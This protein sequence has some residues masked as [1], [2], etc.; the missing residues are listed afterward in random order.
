[1][2]QL[3]YLQRLVLSYCIVL[4]LAD[5]PNL[6]LYEV[7]FVGRYIIGTREFIFPAEPLYEIS[8]L[9]PT[10][11]YERIDRVRAGGGLKSFSDANEKYGKLFLIAASLVIWVVILLLFKVY[12][13]DETW[14][15]WHV[16]VEHPQF[17]DFRLIPG[18]AESFRMGF[19]P[20]QRNPGDPHK[21]IFNYPAFWRL[22]FY[23]GITQEHSLWAVAVML[24]LFFLGVFLFPQNITILESIALLLVIFSP[25]SMLLYERGNVDLIVFFL[26]ALIVWS[27]EI[28]AFVAVALLSFAIVVKI[29]PF[30]G[31]TVLLTESKTRFIWLFL[32]CLAVLLAY[33]YS[34]SGSV[35]AAWN[36]TMRGDEIS[37]GANVLFLRYSQY[38]SQLLRVSQTDPKLKFE[39]VILA[40]ILI[41]IAGLIGIT[42]REPL[43]SASTRNLAAFRMGASI[44]IGTFLLGNN[45][46]YRLAF[47][48]FVVPQLMEWTRKSYPRRYRTIAVSVLILVFTSCWHFVVWFAPGLASVKEFLFVLDETMNWMLVAGFSYLLC[49]SIPDWLRIEFNSSL[50]K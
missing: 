17:S 1:M 46:D 18:S 4:I 22:F 40:A 37:Y 26:C 30:F 9:N 35:R 47:L 44:Y 25:A 39:P 7:V 5:S 16:P 21:R 29:F 42:S 50:Q 12:G 43:K 38:F 33:M 20:T 45:W 3:Y 34:T 2:G 36:L 32:T 48:I 19:E 24:G 11:V 8:A 13:Y 10:S 49:A 28:S 23:T 14:K 31:F 6:A 27:I 15:L 41:G